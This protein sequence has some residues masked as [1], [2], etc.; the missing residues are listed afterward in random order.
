[1]TSWAF[2]FVE[3]TSSQNIITKRSNQKN[4]IGLELI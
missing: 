3:K 1:M 2:A 4:K